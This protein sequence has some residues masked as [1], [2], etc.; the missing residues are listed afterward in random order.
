MIYH[1]LHHGENLINVQDSN[2]EPSETLIVT[3]TS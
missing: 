3:A 1:W 2:L